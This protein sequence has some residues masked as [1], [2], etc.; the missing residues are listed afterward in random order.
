M[1]RKPPEPAV[2]LCGAQL[3]Q[4]ATGVRSGEPAKLPPNVRNIVARYSHRLP[5][6]GEVLD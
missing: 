5:V 6:R 2:D 1:P 4:A 3:R